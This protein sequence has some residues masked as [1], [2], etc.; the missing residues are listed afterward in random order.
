MGSVSLSTYSFRL[1]DQE[2]KK[3]QEDKKPVRFG[4]LNISPYL[5]IDRY[6]TLRRENCSLQEKEKRI[7]K[8]CEILKNGDRILSGI[9]QSGEYGYENELINVENSKKSY[10]KL[11]S[12]AEMHPFYFLMEFPDNKDEG[13]I[14]L[15]RFKQMGIKTVLFSDLSK[16]LGSVYPGY[17]I[18]FNTLTP[19]NLFRQYLEKGKLKKI[20]MIKYGSH[21]DIMDDYA[22]DDHDE[23][24]YIIETIISAKRDSF[25]PKYI[26]NH[27]GRDHL[28][29]FIVGDPIAE[30]VDTLDI[31]ESFAPEEIKLQINIGK[32]QKTLIVDGEKMGR[33]SF[34]I[35]EKIKISNNGHP[36]LMSIDKEARQLLSEI[37]NTM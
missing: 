33:P 14:I 7:W 28:K 9:I 20:R 10:Y 36:E 8:T 13:I 4:D 5:A 16:H 29:D 21:R 25:V 27:L 19:T 30:M 1:Y 32:T 23:Q 37:R 34:D 18:R 17:Q 11:K 15:Q 2:D 35:T 6:L 3:N 31:I 26:I 22:T 12:D 24:K